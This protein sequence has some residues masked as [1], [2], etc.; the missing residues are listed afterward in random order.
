MF[1]KE[2]DSMARH[3]HTM[4]NESTCKVY[5]QDETFTRRNRRQAVG[6]RRDR[7]WGKY[8]RTLFA[9]VV[10]SSSV[11]GLCQAPWIWNPWSSVSEGRATA[12][13]PV[14]AVPYGQRIALFLAD[15]NGGIYTITG[16]PDAGWGLWTSVSEGRSMPGARV[17]A[18]PWKNGFALFV[19]DPNGGVYT[20]TGN[21][22][23]GW[24]PWSSVS[25]GRSAP[26]GTI[27]AVTWKNGFA[28]FLAD[29]NGGIYTATGNP[30]AGWGPW[31]SVSEGRSAPGGT[32][33]AVPW[34]NGFALFL[35][36]PKGGIYTATGNPQ[37]GWGPWSSVSEGRSTPGARVTALPWKNGFALFLADPKG[38]V[39]TA[40][41]N[42][43]AG[44]GPWSSVSEGRS[45]P[46]G[47]ITTVPWKNGLALFLADPNGGIFTTASG[48]SKAMDVV[49]SKDMT[50]DNG[51]LR[52]PLWRQMT[53]TGQ[54]PDPC[55]VCPCSLLHEDPQHWNAAE[56][57]T[58][59]SL[60][61]NSNKRC[62]AGPL[63]SSDNSGL[64]SMMNWFPVEY[65]GRL[66]W[67]GHSNSVTDDD[68]Y[69][70]TI[71]RDDRALETA[72]RDGVHIEFN[73]EET[74]DNWDDTSTWWD[75]FHHKGVDKHHE[76]FFDGPNGI[77]GKQAIVIGM[78]GLD[79]PHTDHH[80][81]LHPVYAMFVQLPLPQPTQ[82]KWAFFVR[83]WGNEGFC[84]SDQEP[85]EQKTIQIRIPQRPGATKF[86]L[87]DNVYGFWNDDDNGCS[88]Q[89]WNYQ[90]VK[91]GV[92]LTFSLQ[93]ASKQCGIMG[94]LT[95]DWGVLESRVVPPPRA[96]R[97][98][99]FS[100]ENEDSVLK[101]KIDK[102]DASSK[103][104]L[105][106]ELMNLT[107]HHNTLRK[108]G[109]NNTSPAA[110]SRKKMVTLPD[111]GRNLKSVAD[112]SAKKA[113]RQEF[114]L[115]FLKAH[116]IK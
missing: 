88:Q 23:I 35:A 56:N 42:P 107:S 102:L 108:R 8:L 39:Y 68:D 18:V 85:I 116:G 17:T 106:Q 90:R 21:P 78:L 66:K 97:A 52:N 11:A 26:G 9:L 55:A 76:E 110:E 111:Y 103:K 65:E 19:A 29:P 53:Q 98:K 38:G 34:K 64:T 44:W 15:P 47:S 100:D 60:H 20:A 81:E 36:D 16:S 24:G 72:G 59:Q 50:D 25:E 80:S 57:C 63:I 27:T 32:I 69:Y 112:P 92:L 14:T 54:P 46:G 99:P 101:S 7:T 43:Q 114:V 94:D 87:T 71:S 6:S 1:D 67:E 109:T 31:S 22:Q 4:S 10:V 113:K 12:G 48:L 74:V 5:I 104:L 95:I 84:G 96:A 105:E 33:T 13:A 86:V 28:L 73:S 45:R 89:S 77:N 41:G 75:D 3:T 51:F 30:Q 37:A 91:D 82:E 83:N 115:S 2:R 79:L 40:T 62:V 58:T 70:L 61:T 49:S 93:D